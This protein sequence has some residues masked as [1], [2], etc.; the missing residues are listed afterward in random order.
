MVWQPEGIIQYPTSDELLKGN[1]RVPGYAAIFRSWGFIGDSLC[2][3]EM[4]C[5]EGQ[6]KKFI[7]MYEYSWG[8][9][10]CRL[11]GSEGYNYSSGG[12][13]AQGWVTGSSNRTWSGA[14]SKSHQIYI[15]ALGVNDANTSIEV[16]DVN[17]DIDLNNYE[18]NAATFAG[19]YAGIIQR[20]RSIS[21]RS[22]IFVVSIP[23]NNRMNP[24]IKAM[25]DKFNNVFLIDLSKIASLYG[26]TIF[27]EKYRLGF[28]MNPAGYLY[29]AYLFMHYIDCFIQKNPSIFKD[30]AL[31]NTNYTA[32]AT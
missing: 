25:P 10:I 14:K 19:Y 24:I 7:D 11:C 12:Q 17:S 8:Q 15:I 31:W 1:L 28:H 20:I 30:V 3:G 5:Y 26:N 21:R 16:G 23:D 4:E 18:N 29:T 6:T 13:T 22:I 32:Q 27:N 9:Q 2:S